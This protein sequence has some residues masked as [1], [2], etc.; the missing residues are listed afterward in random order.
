[1]ET[2]NLTGNSIAT[3]L[4]MKY[5]LT[6]QGVHKIIR[7]KNHSATINSVKVMKDLKDIKEILERETT[8][9]V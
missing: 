4:S 3:L 5:G 2:K 7:S 8:V 1:M 9:T 6:R